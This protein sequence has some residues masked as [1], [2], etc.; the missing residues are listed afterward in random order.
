M[1]EFSIAS[2]IISIALAEAKRRY[3]KRVLEIKIRIGKFSFINPDQL[4]FSL[5][6][7]ASMEPSLNGVVFSVSEEDAVAKCI[8]CNYQWIVECK[9]NPLY[10]YSPPIVRCPRCNN[11]SKLVKGRDCVIEGI[12]IEV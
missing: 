10:H 11:I 9:D 12:C 3:A 5:E 6:A 8:E 1:H 7:I 2:Q 4:K